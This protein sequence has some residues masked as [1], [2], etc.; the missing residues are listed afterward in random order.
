[1]SNDVGND[2]GYDDD[3]DGDDGD[4]RPSD[5]KRNTSALLLLL[6]SDYIFVFIFNV[7]LFLFRARVLYSLNDAASAAVTHIARYS[8][9]I[10]ASL[11]QP[12]IRLV[13]GVQCVQC[14]I[15]FY[16][17]PLFSVHASAIK[18]CSEFTNIPTTTIIIP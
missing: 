14:A 16:L 12:F 1:M 8:S 7:F 11:F 6:M 4:E 5:E 3:N 10:V 15:S 2:N 13:Y 9:T 17:S 18:V